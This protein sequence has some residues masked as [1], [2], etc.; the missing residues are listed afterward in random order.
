[1]Q[2]LDKLKTKIKTFYNLSIFNLTQ[3]KLVNKGVTLLI[4][5]WPQA[6]KLAFIQMF[7][8]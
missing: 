5:F 8:N 3:A 1:M 7:D 2:I 4:N 6:T